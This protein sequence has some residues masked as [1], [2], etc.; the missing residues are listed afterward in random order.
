MIEFNGKYL[1]DS[2]ENKLEV[3]VQYDGSNIHIWHAPETFFKLAT[4]N[5]FHAF[6]KNGSKN[7]S[8]NL[9]NGDRIETHDPV[10][11]LLVHTTSNRKQASLLKI[12]PLIMA[13]FVALAMVWA[14]IKFVAG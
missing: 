4:F 14:T 5:Q 6:G 2:S 1:Q 9:P 12:S 7:I 3:L 10:A 13:F 11:G 8:I